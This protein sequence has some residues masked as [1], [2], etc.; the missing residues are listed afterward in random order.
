MWHER[1]SACTSHHGRTAEALRPVRG[2]R[3]SPP[4]GRTWPLIFP[5]PCAILLTRQRAG[6]SAAA[7]KQ[8]GP[9][10]VMVSAQRARALMPSREET[11]SSPRIDKHDRSPSQRADAP[12]ASSR[13]A[14]LAAAASTAGGVAAAMTTSPPTKAQA[15]P[16]PAPDLLDGAYS[17]TKQQV[18]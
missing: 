4:T 17:A 10:R 1:N 5:E 9:A 15:A 11:M 18:R 16:G 8:A 12:H 13:P 2:P 3:I 7:A 6:V 14:V